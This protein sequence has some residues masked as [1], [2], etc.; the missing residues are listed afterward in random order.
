MHTVVIM[1][2]P[3]PIRD[4]MKTFLSAP[5][6]VNLSDEVMMRNP[7][8]IRDAMKTFLSAPICVNLS[9]KVIMRNPT[10]ISDAMRAWWELS[11]HLITLLQS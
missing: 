3:T 8:P 9:H 7:P 6:C 11:S 10:L 1:R 5:I 4:A 2:N